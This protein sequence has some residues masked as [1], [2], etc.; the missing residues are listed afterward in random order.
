MEYKYT[1]ELRA[2]LERIEE[3]NKTLSS[4]NLPDAAETSHLASALRMAYLVSLRV[5]LL[6]L[7]SA[8]DEWADAG[9]KMEE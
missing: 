3:V 2:V 1:P 8:L 7:H 5:D 4:E 6:L 9:A